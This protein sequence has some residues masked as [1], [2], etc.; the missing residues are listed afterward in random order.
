MRLWK[1]REVDLD[2]AKRLAAKWYKK[3]RGIVEFGDLLS[4]A[5]IGAVEAEKIKPG[6]WMFC[7]Q[8]M[9]WRILDEV[10]SWNSV[11]RNA[12]KAGLRRVPYDAVMEPST[13]MEPVLDKSNLG[14]AMEA[15]TSRER[16]V[17]KLKYWKGMNDVEVATR[18]RIS[19]MRIG[20][21]NRAAL[22]KLQKH[23][24]VGGL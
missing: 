11:K 18:L 22:G 23:F 19:P 7:E 9:S 1:G 24:G 12:Y 13:A 3:T 15:L 6:D 21:L 10:R 4:A 8:R 5:A 14:K 20:Q 2:Q 16:Q 17:V